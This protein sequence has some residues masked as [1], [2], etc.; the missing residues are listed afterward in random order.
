MPAR[1]SSSGVNERTVSVRFY[2]FLLFLLV[3]L[4]V[5]AAVLKPQTMADYGSYVR[6]FQGISQNERME[7]AFSLIVWSLNFVDG[8]NYYLLFFVFALISIPLRVY[9]LNK[10]SPVFWGSIIVYLSNWYILHDLIQ[11]RAG[12]AS[13]LLIIIVYFSYKRN[14]KFFLLFYFLSICFHYSAILFGLIWFVSRKYNPKNFFLLLMFSYLIYFV[15]FSWV[16][17]IQYIP[18]FSISSLLTQYAGREAYGNNPF[19]LIQLGRIALA[20]FFFLNIRKERNRYPWYIF[21]LK[22]YVLGLC[23]L[24]LFSSLSGVA[25]RTMELFVSCEPIVIPIG[26]LISLKNK[27]LTNLSI[28]SYS[29]VLFYIFYNT[30]NYWNVDLNFF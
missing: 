29:I 14:L 28:I 27:L 9:L 8:N 18:F 3:G 21:F 10:F 1:V 5:Y 6:L 16:P 25:L 23:F 4:L 26:F 7:P 2:N 13:A 12:V 20:I 24:P 30:P 22:V 17:L 15:K 11:I 19:N